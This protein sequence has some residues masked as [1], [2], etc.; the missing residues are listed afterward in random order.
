MRSTF[1]CSSNV[2]WPNNFLGII[3]LAGAASLG[4][5]RLTKR[6]VDIYYHRIQSEKGRFSNGLMLVSTLTEYVQLDC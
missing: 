3:Q 6:K 1:R 5:G 4:E 2:R